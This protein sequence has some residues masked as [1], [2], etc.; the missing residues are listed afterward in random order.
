MANIFITGGA[1]FLGWKLVKNLLNE[2][3]SKLYLLVRQNSRKNVRERI[4]ELINKSYSRKKIKKIRSRIEVVKGDITEK[5]FGMK[6][7]Q[8]GNLSK[9]I[10]IIYHCAA[11]CQFNVPMSIIRKI[12]VGGTRNVLDFALKCKANGKFKS[13]HHISTVAIMGDAGGVLCENSLDI[14]QRFNNTYERTKFEAEKLINKYRKKGL[15]VSI[16]RPSVIVGD[17]I[18]GEASDFQ[19]FYRPLHIFSM[20]ILEEIPASKNLKY[21]LVPVNYVARVIYLISSNEKNDNGNYHLTNPHNITLNAFLNIASSYFGFKKPNI[22]LG[23]KFNFK[24]LKG[25]RRKVIEPYLPYFNHK[26]IA[27]GMANFNRAIKSTGFVWPAIDRKLLF[28]LF[29]YCVDVKYINKKIKL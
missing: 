15:K 11:L 22:T 4:E 17:S 9:K 19:L 16:Y 5:N 12:N 20:E 8:I 29:K 6:K 28:R 3:D 26:K 10:G 14:G 23:N 1:G 2:T 21:N 27:F 24:K 7:T 18:T 13:F 25:F